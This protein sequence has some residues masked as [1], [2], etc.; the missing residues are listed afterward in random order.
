MNLNNQQLQIGELPELEIVPLS[1]IVFHE[2]PDIERSS[3]LVIFLRKDGRLKNPPMV[4][5]YRDESHYILLDGANRMTALSQIGIRDVVVQKVNL[6][7][8]KLLFLHW[9]HAVEKFTKEEFLEKLGLIDGLIIS[10]DNTGE[11]DLDED[12]ELLCQI[13]FSDSELYQISA[14]CDL[15]EKVSL[16]K[17]ITNI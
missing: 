17:K 12:C 16:L 3:S 14:D 1:Q 6:F 7:D 4:A 8:E 2:D 5:Y 9:H 15:F 13:Q 11:L 10:N